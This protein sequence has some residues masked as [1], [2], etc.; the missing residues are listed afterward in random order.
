MQCDTYDF[1]VSASFV[2]WIQLMYS[3]PKATIKVNG[4]ISPPFHLTRG[5]QQGCP[6]SPL[7]FAMSIE[8]MALAIR[9]YPQV[10]RFLY[11]TL[12]ENILMYADDTIL[13]LTDHYT[14]FQSVLDIIKHFGAS[15]SIG[16]DPLFFPLMI[17][18]QRCWTPNANLK[19][20]PPLNI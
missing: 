20:L 4:I 17:R 12:E 19:L 9:H 14:S 11:K 2:K 1:L 15:K 6:I 16:K 13:Y 5:T 3:E 18:S 7:L 8:P 10:R